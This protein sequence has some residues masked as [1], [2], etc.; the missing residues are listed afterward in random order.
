M[1]QRRRGDEE[2]E[3]NEG[4]VNYAEKEGDEEREGNEGAVNDAEE[5]R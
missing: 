4:A 2:R 3:G 5:R 1:M